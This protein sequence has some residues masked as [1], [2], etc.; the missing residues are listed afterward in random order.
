MEQRGRDGAAGAAA[1]QVVLVDYDPAWPRRFAAERARLAP[2]L[3]AFAATV[4]HVGS[5]AVPGLYAKPIIDLLA[6]VPQLEPATGYA[7][8]LAAYGYVLRVDPAN[9]QRHAFGLRDVQGR[10]PHPGYNLHVVEW[11]GI[12]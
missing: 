4:E 7:T 10:R 5:T 12:E 6:L 8:V 3:I 1:E 11:D 9:T 2:A